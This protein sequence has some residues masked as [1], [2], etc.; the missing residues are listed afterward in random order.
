[1]LMLLFA[2]FARAPRDARVCAARYAAR[3]QRE[4]AKEC[5]LRGVRVQADM[6]VRARCGARAR[7]ARSRCAQVRARA[8]SRARARACA[9]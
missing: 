8:R 4:K 6:R 2:A 9:S 1:M 7:G 5:A 3:M